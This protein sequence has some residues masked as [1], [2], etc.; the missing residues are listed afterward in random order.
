MIDHREGHG[1]GE[2]RLTTQIRLAVGET[3]LHKHELSGIHLKARHTCNRSAG[4]AEAR[5]S[6]ELA[7][8]IH[9]PQVQ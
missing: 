4:E 6:L 1:N 2:D 8:Q 9:E 3:A 5:D 7:G